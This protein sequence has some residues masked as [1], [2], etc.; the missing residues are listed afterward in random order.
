MIKLKDSSILMFIPRFLRNDKKIKNLITAIDTVLKEVLE[1]VSSMKRMQKISEGEL[2][3]AEIELLLWEKHVDYFDKTLTKEQKIKLIQNAER[4][5]LK[6]GTRSVLETHLKIIFGEL[7]LQEWFE[8]GAQPF[9]FQILT[10]YQIT[11]DILIRLNRTVDEFQTTRSIFEG[12]KIN[13]NLELQLY[14]GVAVHNIEETIIRV[15]VPSTILMMNN[16]IA[17]QSIEEQNIKIGIVD[18]MLDSVEAINLELKN[19][20]VIHNIEESIIKIY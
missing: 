7:Q 10:D 8:Y 19:S 3:D 5:H 17:I 2:T 4:A 1:R 14:E 20:T 11:D 16:S 15:D 9:H 6:K 13:V 18:N 12:V